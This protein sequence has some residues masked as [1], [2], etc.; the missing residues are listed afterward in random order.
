MI[1]KQINDPLLRNDPTLPFL[2]ATH[3]L[4][5]AL[6]VLFELAMH[7]S[8]VL[9]S[10]HELLLEPKRN[11]DTVRCA[12]LAA[13]ASGHCQEQLMQTLIVSL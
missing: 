11:N 12:M 2:P 10:L 7:S 9:D 1:P 3:Y 6:D 5:D 13:E 8:W 4:L